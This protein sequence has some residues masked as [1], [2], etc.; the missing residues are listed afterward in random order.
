MSFTR[1]KQI[2]MD[3]V[4]IT[5][6]PLVSKDIDVLLEKQLAIFSDKESPLDQK[7]KSLGET[8]FQMIA[9]GLNNANGVDPEHKFTAENVQTQFD[10]RLLKKLKDEIADMSGIEIRDKEISNTGEAKASSTSPN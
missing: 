7:A 4:S 10:K 9:D 8:W 5:I 6:A 3:G 2:E 1:K